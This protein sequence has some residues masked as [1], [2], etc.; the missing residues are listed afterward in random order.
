M[1]QILFKLFS[2]RCYAAADDKAT[3]PATANDNM[4]AGTVLSGLG[5]TNKF[6]NIVK[7]TEFP[8]NDSVCGEKKTVDIFTREDPA[9]DADYAT[10]PKGSKVSR[11]IVASGAV[12]DA[13]EYLL[14]AEGFALNEA[15]YVKELTLTNAQVLAL[16]TTAIDFLASPGTTK[17]IKPIRGEI[18]HNYATAA[19]GLSDVTDI[20]FKYTNAS[21][22]ALVK[23]PTTGVLDQA[24]NK[25][26]F[27]NAETNCIGVANAKVVVHAHGSADPATG[28]GTVTVKLFYQVVA[29]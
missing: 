3:N 24:A 2:V 18:R 5:G 14:K 4:S 6:K 29:A 22:A 25:K 28:G 13:E 21:G 11:H 8:Y 19:F 15:V 12:V 9:G 20:E 10:L 1:V 7:T 27:S 17:I 26:A 16:N 23:V